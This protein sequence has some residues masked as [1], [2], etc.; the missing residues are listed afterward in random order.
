MLDQFCLIWHWSALINIGINARFFID[1]GHWSR[2]SWV[3]Q[4][5]FY[6]GMTCC[7]F[8]ATNCIHIIIVS[9]TNRQ[10]HAKRSQVIV[11]P[12]EGYMHHTSPKNFFLKSWNHTK[13]WCSHH[14]HAHFWLLQDSRVFAA[15]PIIIYKISVL[16]HRFMKVNYVHKF[17][18]ID[19]SLLKNTCCF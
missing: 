9:S 4:M 14:T 19:H 18:H 12:K 11:I 17:R 1:I 2:E 7:Q 8:I 5:K 6:I 16:Q 15:C 3:Q 10:C 13:L